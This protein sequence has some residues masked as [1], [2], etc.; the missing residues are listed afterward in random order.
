MWDICGI[1]VGHIGSRQALCRKW[2]GIYAEHVLKKIVT[3]GIRLSENGT[4]PKK[5]DSEKNKSQNKVTK[6][7]SELN[8]V[9]KTD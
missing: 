2:T 3:F 6:K 4:I 1:Y 7:E 5:S 8:V 9:D